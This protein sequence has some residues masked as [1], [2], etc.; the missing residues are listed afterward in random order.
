MPV[1]SA[2]TFNDSIFFSYKKGFIINFTVIFQWVF[3]VCLDLFAWK[4]DS[5]GRPRSGVKGGE[6]API[7]ACP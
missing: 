4:T 7:G 6:A 3:P 2:I 5:P 1:F